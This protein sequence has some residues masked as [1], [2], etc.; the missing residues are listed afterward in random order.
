MKRLLLLFFALGFI[1]CLAQAQTT[2]QIYSRWSGRM[3]ICS[4]T[5][6]LFSAY[7]W[8]SSTTYAGPYSVINGATKQYYENGGA[9]LQG[10]YYVQVTYK[11]GSTMNSNILGLHTQVEKVSVYPNPASK[12]S[13]V[14]V[15]TTSPDIQMAT[16]QIFTANGIKV[17]EYNTSDASADIEAPATTGCYLVRIRLE[18]GSTV[19][20]KLFVK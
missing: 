17:R 1:I 8:Y 7:Q 18:N 14:K 5:L 16:V 2:P 10:Y 3:V 13:S 15:E 12:S 20:Q 19:T 11:T 6:N 4:D 9:G